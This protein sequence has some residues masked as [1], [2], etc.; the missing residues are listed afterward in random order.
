MTVDENLFLWVRAHEIEKLNKESLPASVPLI[1]LRT[2]AEVSIETRRWVQ[3]DSEYP[4][5]CPQLSDDRGHVRGCDTQIASRACK[6]SANPLK[7]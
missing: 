1:I 7:R 4:G 5:V 6:T 2:L 3:L